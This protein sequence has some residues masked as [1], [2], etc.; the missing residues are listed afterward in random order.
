MAA[1]T[2]QDHKVKDD[3]KSKDA[4]IDYRGAKYTVTADAIDNLELFED[5]EDGRYMSALK[6]F[7]GAKQ[8]AD[9]KDSIRN[10]E[11]RVPM[12]DAEDFISLVM[13]AVGNLGASQKS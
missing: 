8:W 1:K 4:T 10:A 7:L 13:E 6:G 9:F 2:P 3:A 11:G 5:V 12:S